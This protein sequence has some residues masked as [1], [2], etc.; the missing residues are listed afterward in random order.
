MNNLRVC[1]YCL[2]G[3]FGFSTEAGRFFSHYLKITM[4]STS[5]ICEA[6]SHTAKIDL[7]KPPIQLTNFAT[8]S[9]EN[10]IAKNIYFDNLIKEFA[11]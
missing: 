1:H 11:D 8:L 4:T 10:E 5:K 9:I 3:C 7:C 2:I 6:T